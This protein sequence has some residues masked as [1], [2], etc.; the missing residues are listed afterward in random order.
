MVTTHVPNCVMTVL[1]YVFNFMCLLIILMSLASVTPGNKFLNMYQ[2]IMLPSLP[3]YILYGTVSLLSPVHIYNFAVNIDWFLFIC[4]ESTLT[5]SILPLLYPWDISFHFIY[6]P[7][8]FAKADLLEV[9]HLATCH[10]HL[11]ICW[12]LSQLV[13]SPTISTWLHCG[14]Q[15]TGALVVSSFALFDIFILSN[16]LESVTM[17]KTAA[18]ALYTSTLFVQAS[19][20]P[21]VICS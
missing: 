10:T 6:C 8:P 5:V 12:A 4:T 14:V 15:P 19:T 7:A 13:Y 16:C 17:F 3:V 2:G 9:L 21:F 1:L 18:L 20:P 11:A